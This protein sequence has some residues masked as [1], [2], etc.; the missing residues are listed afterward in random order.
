RPPPRAPLRPADTQRDLLG[1]SH[2]GRRP[3][4]GMAD[5]R[6]Q[7]D[8]PRRLCRA[9][10]A[11]PALLRPESWLAP[12]RRSA[13]RGLDRPRQ[14]PPSRRRRPLL[15]R[16]MDGP[17]KRRHRA[18]GPRTSRGHVIAMNGTEVSL[19]P[20]KS[21]NHSVMK[22]TAKPSRVGFLG[23]GYIADWHAK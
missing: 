16:T 2:P 11:H 7:P 15:A 3:R 20:R 9:L 8:P 6:Y 18:Q 23:T 21:S 22:R 5:P 14:V 4:H 12:W 13:V 19:A 17:A 10:L 1:H